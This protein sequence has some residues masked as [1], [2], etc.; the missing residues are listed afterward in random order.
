MTE[1]AEHFII[2]SKLDEGAFGE[3]YSGVCKKDNIKVAI[4]HL[5]SRMKSWDD[6][7]QMRE[8]KSL[9]QL[10]HPNIVKLKEARKIENDLYLVFEF[11]ETDLYKMYSKMKQ[12]VNYLVF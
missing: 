3:V 2:L 9:S 10:N 4:K 8:I 7:L 11:M 1:I 5:K 6:C 12:E